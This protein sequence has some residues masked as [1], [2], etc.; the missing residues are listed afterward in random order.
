M[1]PIFQPF[2][3]LLARSTAD[4]LQKQIEF[5]KAENE[6]LRKRV[7]KQRIILKADEPNRLI[8]LGKELGLPDVFV[9]IGSHRRRGVSGR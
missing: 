1:G 2:L 7:P 3:F 8:K 5:L 4:D 9:G 6:M